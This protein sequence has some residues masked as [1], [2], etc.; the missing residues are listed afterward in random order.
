VTFIQGGVAVAAAAELLKTPHGNA[1]FHPDA[2]QDY[3]RPALSAEQRF[4]RCGGW[5]EV[6]DTDRAR[7]LTSAG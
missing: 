2:V 3:L 1:K 7:S 6:R 4:E 5:P